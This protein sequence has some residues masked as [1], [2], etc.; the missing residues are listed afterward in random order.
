MKRVHKK[1]YLFLG[2]AALI[3]A[4]V[5]DVLVFVSFSQGTIPDNNKIFM[6][7]VAA[8]AGACGVAGIVGIILFFAKTYEVKEK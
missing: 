1:S 7:V 3:L 6:I 2:L 8:V 5:V 4:I